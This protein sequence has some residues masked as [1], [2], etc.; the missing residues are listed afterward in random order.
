ME[1]NN[2]IFK[3]GFYHEDVLFSMY[4]FFYA[5]KIIG[6]NI[7]L[8]NY[9]Q[10][11]D[12]SICTNIKLKNL[13]DKSIICRELDS[14]YRAHEFENVHFYNAIYHTYL[15]TI[16]QGISNG[17]HAQRKQFF[18]KEDIDIM[19]KGVISTYEFKLW[20]LACIDTKLMVKY[21]ENQLNKYFRRLINLTFSLFFHNANKNYI[22]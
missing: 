4:V 16:T 8:C 18:Y 12:G 9:R 14:F 13:T 15:Y 2:L 5:I 1:C 19:K 10:H 11:R 6:N 17:Y 7:Q 3:E 22:Q 20:L 21:Y